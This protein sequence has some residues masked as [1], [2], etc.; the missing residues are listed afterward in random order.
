MLSVAHC[1]GVTTPVALTN[2]VTSSITG[3]GVGDAWEA[4]P[5]QEVSKRTLV[6]MIEMKMEYGL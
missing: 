1:E 3:S 5:L 4:N 6:V 2:G